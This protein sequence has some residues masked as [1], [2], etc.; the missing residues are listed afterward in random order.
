MIITCPSCKKK[1]NIDINLIPAEGRNLQC[2]SCDRVWFYKKEDPIPEPL[3]INENISI[4]VVFNENVTVTSGTTPSITLNTGTATY[5]SSSSS[6]NTLVFDY[7][8]GAGHTAS[9][10]TITEVS[11][12]FLIRGIEQVLF[13]FFILPKV[14]YELDLINL[15][16]EEIFFWLFRN[17]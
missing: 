9:P 8:V 6:S 4:N 2:G 5:N 15:K 10:L 14:E 1:F 13:I 17:K 16:T 11:G 3:Q 12:T 7:T